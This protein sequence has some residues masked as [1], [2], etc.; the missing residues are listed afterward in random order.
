V[1]L[2]GPTEVSKK[3]SAFGKKGHYEHADD[4]EQISDEE[5]AQH[6]GRYRRKRVVLRRNLKMEPPQLSS[7]Q[8]QLSQS[9]SQLSL[10]ALA[11]VLAGVALSSAGAV[12]GGVGPLGG[13]RF[14][15]DCRSG[16]SPRARC[17]HSRTRIYTCKSYGC[18]LDSSRS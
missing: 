6:E 3:A 18:S 1:L 2:P 9:Q 17:R 4:D 16:P 8:S 15:R 11:V 10:V 14:H 7:R 12:S 5:D 13:C